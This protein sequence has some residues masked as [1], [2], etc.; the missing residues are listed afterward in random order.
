VVCS[1]SGVRGTDELG[2]SFLS[3][4]CSF[5][6]PQLRFIGASF[7]STLPN[8]NS[9]V[10]PEIVLLL[11]LTAFVKLFD[12]CDLSGFALHLS[13]GFYESHVDLFM[14]GPSQ[15]TARNRF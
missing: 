15:F 13:S 11:K 2:V 7:G 9:H 14:D 8:L 6:C 5:S 1:E 3:S 10:S 12:F 4:L